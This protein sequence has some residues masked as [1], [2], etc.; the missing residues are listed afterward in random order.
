MATA[1]LTVSLVSAAAAVVAAVMAGISIGISRRATKAAEASAAE[2]RRTADAE[3]R[4]H[5]IEEDRR[6]DEKRPALDG[7]VVPA[8]NGHSRYRLEVWLK[9][10][11]P[12][13]WVTLTV[14]ANCGFYKGSAVMSHDLSYP[15]GDRQAT[16]KTRDVIPWPVHLSENAQGTV[17]VPAKCRMDNGILY[18]G[19]VIPIDLDT[20]GARQHSASS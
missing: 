5:Q 12:L 8:Q 2:A 15:V 18:E 16:I 11:E 7:R 3:E 10:A 14:P 20:A 13:M 1:A 6:Y 19:L 9:T 4:L 17:V